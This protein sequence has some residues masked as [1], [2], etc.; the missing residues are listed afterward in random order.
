MVDCQI[1]PSDVTDHR[2]TA[3]LEEVPR[4]RFLPE[5]RRH[6]AYFDGDIV[7]EGGEVVLAPRVFAKMLQVVRVAPEDVVLDI[8][9]ALGYS[10]AVLS[11]LASTVVALE[12]DPAVVDRATEALAAAGVENCAVLAEPLSGGDAANGPYD[13]IFVNGGAEHLPPTLPEQLKEGGRLVIVMLS[14]AGGECQR[15]T[16]TGNAFGRARCFDATAPLLP[17]FERMAEFTF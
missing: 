4:E 10:S 17:G 7:L 9:C 6:A 14:G 15:I 3:A 8:G 13:V 12:S 5:S 1:R 16:R 2:I 11:R